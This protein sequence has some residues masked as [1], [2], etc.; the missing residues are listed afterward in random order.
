MSTLMLIHRIMRVSSRENTILLFVIWLI[1]G[2]TN[3]QITLCGRTEGIL[4]S[5]NVTLIPLQL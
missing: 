2:Y 5:L 4:S 1:V 3:R